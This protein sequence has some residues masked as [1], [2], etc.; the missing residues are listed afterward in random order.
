MKVE[1]RLFLGVAAFMWATSIGYGYWSYHDNAFT[2]GGHHEIEWA[3]FAALVL[4]GGLC[5]IVGSF[6]WFVSRR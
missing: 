1:A 2:P 3:G 5:A 6:F 4:S